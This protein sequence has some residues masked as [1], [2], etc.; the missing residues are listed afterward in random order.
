MG[1]PDKQP[2]HRPTADS[3]SDDNRAIEGLPVRLVIALVVGVAALGIMMTIMGDVGDIGTNDVTYDVADPDTDEL[4][5]YLS[6]PAGSAEHLDNETI[7]VVDDAGQIVPN[8][9]VILTAGDNARLSEPLTFI[10]DDDGQAQLST[11]DNELSMPREHTTGTLD[12]E[13]IPPSGTDLEDS[14]TNPPITVVRG[15]NPDP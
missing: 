4:T 11:S 7:T 12:V 10:T 15:E 2:R 8:A 5:V 3:L 9:Q 6:V 14:S 13:I 1:M